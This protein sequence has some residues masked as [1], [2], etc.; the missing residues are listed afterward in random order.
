MRSFLSKPSTPS[1]TLRERL[2]YQLESGKL[3]RV[4]HSF[5]AQRRLFT[6]SVFLDSG[7]IRCASLEVANRSQITIGRF[8][9]L[10]AGRLFY[11]P[12]KAPQV[13]SYHHPKA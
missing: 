11:G 13:S 4:F 3:S 12:C 7:G 5:S 2:R 10:A 9:E 6:R 1:G 8:Q